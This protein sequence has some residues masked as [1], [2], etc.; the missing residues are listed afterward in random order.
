M[1]GL[2]IMARYIPLILKL[3]IIGVAS[4]WLYRDS[5]ARDYNWVIWTFM[6]VTALFTPDNSF[7][8]LLIALLVIIYLCCRPK[9]AL[10]LCPHCNKKIHNELFVCPFC[11]KNAKKECLHC[12]E[13]VPWDAEQCPYCKSKAITKS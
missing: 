12:H 9:G 13:P 1:K 4:F 3:I 2:K 11:R 6:P 10:S 5:R 8:I 7:S